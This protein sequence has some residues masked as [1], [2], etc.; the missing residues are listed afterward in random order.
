MYQYVSSVHEML[1]WPMVHSLL[2]SV[3]TPNPLVSLDR[4]GASIVL[5]LY[6][7]TEPLPVT[8]TGPPSITG[9]SALGSP[10]GSQEERRGSI[11]ATKVASIISWPT[12]HSLSKSYFETFNLMY[13]IVDRL[14]FTSTVLPAINDRGLDDSTYSALAYLVF[15][16]GEVAIAGVQ[17]MPTDLK[18]VRQ[19]GIKGGSKIQPPGLAL[20]NEGRKR[21]GFAL[22]ECSLENVQ[23]FALAGYGLPSSLLNVKAAN[24]GASIYYETCFHHMVRCLPSD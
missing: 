22:T 11:S 13:P 9:M 1:A 15:A 14:T 16:L 8:T 6:Q 2:G 3:E 21:M 19:S 5:G 24:A 12:M 20:F 10:L 4:H 7:E 18:N 23:I 17:G